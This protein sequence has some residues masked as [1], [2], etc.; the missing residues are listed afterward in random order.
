MT[1][2]STSRK[3]NELI[4]PR[5]NF[6]DVPL[7]ALRQKSRN[8]LSLLLNSEKILVTEDGY[9][10]DWRGV[11]SL[12]GLTQS[13]FSLISQSQDKTNKLFDIWIK[14]TKD[15]N[16]DVNLSQ[17]QE[18]FGIIDRYDIYDDTL[19]LFTEDANAF[20]S[21]SHCGD[22]G[23][24]SS[25]E[26]I[27][28]DPDNDIIT[29]HDLERR[30]KGLP[31]KI[32]DAFVIYNDKDVEFASEL[33]EKCENMGYSL[34][35]KD[36]DLLGGLSFESEAILDLLSKRCNRLIVIV[37]KAFLKSPMQLFI[38]NF[39]QALG[40]EQKKRKIIPCLLEPCQLPQML[41]YCFGLEYYKVN[42]MYNF[43]DKL[44]KSLK[45][46]TEV[47]RSAKELERANITEIDAGL[48]N[49][50]VNIPT[51][52][53][54]FYDKDHNYKF[55]NTP[56]PTPSERTSQKYFEEK[57]SPEEKRRIMPPPPKLRPA[58]SMLN[59]HDNSNNG[60]STSFRNKLSQSSFFLNQ[61]S[62]DASGIKSKRKKWYKMFLP[63][64][65][66]SSK[67]KTIEENEVKV[68][69]DKRPWY[70]IKKKDKSKEKIAIPC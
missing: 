66:K 57:S 55:T 40:I 44:D 41:K 17:L 27:K 35:A 38:T 51:T 29:L 67:V 22:F 11:F 54:N 68:S 23:S 39:A 37:S 45:E 26:I 3:S 58:S 32:Y 30:E 16:N 56:T 33:I 6:E 31:L 34:C 64:S 47:K 21:K 62:S 18:V 1:F 59:I 52:P 20:L 4:E 69:K 10:R 24:R 43:W 46:T 9:Y 7:Q 5:V 53:G 63:P 19:S 49:L 50:K 8:K 2:Q 60:E 14:H 13:E 42:K 65:G 25:L 70:K 36:R 48:I 61:S 15:N 12:S 28:A